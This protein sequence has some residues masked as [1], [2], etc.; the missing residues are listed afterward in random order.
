MR[1]VLLSC[2]VS[3]LAVACTAPYRFYNLVE[4]VDS[5]AM[6]SNVLQARQT[7]LSGRS[8]QVRPF[9]V[10]GFFGISMCA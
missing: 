1:R 8:C 3:T 10:S 6:G 7:N 9:F 5:Q 4:N 2:T